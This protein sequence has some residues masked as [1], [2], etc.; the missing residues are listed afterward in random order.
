MS[1]TSMD[2]IDAALVRLTYVK[3]QPSVRL[4]AFHT[5]PFAPELHRR[6]TTIVANQKGSLQEISHLNFALGEAFAGAAQAICRRGKISPSR[7]QVVG[8]HGQT[9]WH[10]PRPVAW[11]EESIRS[12]L[13]LGEPSIIAERL[14]ITTVADFRPADMAAGG[15]GAPLSAWFHYLLFRKHPRPVAVHNLGG[16]SNL[17]YI[18]R[19]ARPRDVIAFDTGPG[20]MLIDGLIQS[21]TRG[22]QSH[23]VGGRLAA[24]GRI[25]LKVVA[26]LL[27]H[28]FIVARP[29]K[30]TGREEFGT[31]FVRQVR[32]L[33]GRRAA[34]DDL[35]ATATAFTASAIAENYRRFILTR[36]PRRGEV[37]DGGLE[38]I[39]FCGGGSHNKTLLKMIGR[40]LGGIRLS[41]LDD[42]G[43]PVDAAEAVCFAVLGAQAITGRPNHL[44]QATGARREIVLGK[45]IPGRGFR[46]IHRV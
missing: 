12:T 37:P 45:I 14:G 23:D 30:T 35:V 38:E 18:P 44:P 19:G 33:A 13:Q 32:R 10:Q 34:L 29:P 4:L 21:A 8:S 6:L 25:D 39:V 36:G 42:Y 3:S 26:R 43:I 9:V 41:T 28:P 15:H 27:R 11:G 31:S 24:R 46:G 20:N 22:R 1:G 16:I 40:E 17:T 5:Y 7:G 2:G